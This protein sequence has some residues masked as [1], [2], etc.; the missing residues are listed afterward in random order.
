MRKERE[1]VANSDEGVRAE[2]KR[3]YKQRDGYDETAMAARRDGNDDKADH[4][5]DKGNKI[6]SKIRELKD[7]LKDKKESNTLDANLLERVL[8]E[9]NIG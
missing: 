7:K 3:L 4:F 1:R 9:L 5:E 8:K 6:S 2:I